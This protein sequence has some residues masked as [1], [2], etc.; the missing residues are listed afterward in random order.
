MFNPDCRLSHR[1]REYISYV[2]SERIEP[3][4]RTQREYISYVHSQ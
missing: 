3:S 2:H 1:E 4:L